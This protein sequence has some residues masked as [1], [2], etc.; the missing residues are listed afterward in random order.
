MQYFVSLQKN[1]K[2]ISLS[3]EFSFDTFSPRL[4]KQKNLS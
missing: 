4:P 2:K 3:R 1:V